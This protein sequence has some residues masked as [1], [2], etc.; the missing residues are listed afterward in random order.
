MTR[1][2]VIHDLKNERFLEKLPSKASKVRVRLD[3][4]DPYKNPLTPRDF[5]SHQVSKQTNEG[6]FGRIV[7]NICAIMAYELGPE[8]VETICQS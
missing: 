7:S 8:D 6:A 5:N 2:A 4:T 1:L 3:L